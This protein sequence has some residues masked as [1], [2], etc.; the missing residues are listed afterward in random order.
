MEH[1]QIFGL[2]QWMLMSCSLKKVML[3][4]L[5]CTLVFPFCGSTTTF[6]QWVCYNSWGRATWWISMEHSYGSTWAKA[7][8]SSGQ[9]PPVGSCSCV[10]LKYNRS[11]QRDLVVRQVKRGNRIVINYQSQPHQI[12][13]HHFLIIIL[14]NNLHLYLRIT[15][16]FKHNH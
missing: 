15:L 16:S 2:T 14:S 3:V 8:I 12:P 11:W 7:H 6:N 10:Q 9:L 13:T 1:P 5:I 4:F